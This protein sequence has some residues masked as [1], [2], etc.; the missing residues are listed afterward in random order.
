MALD[1]TQTTYG[2]AELAREFGITTRAI[3]FYEDKGLL[4]PARDGQR[5]IYASRDHVR[6]RLIMRGKRLGFSL[7]E[8]REMID[9]YDLDPT[10]VSQLKMFIDKLQARREQLRRQQDD[11]IETLAELDQLE[12]QSRGLLADREARRK[13]VG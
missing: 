8:I 3:R 6:L 13:A 4:S 1:Q 9:L 10:E 5:R 2:I 11:I 7:D 12:D